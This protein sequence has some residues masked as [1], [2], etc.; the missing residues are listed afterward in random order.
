MFFCVLGIKLTSPGPVLF[1]QARI[2]YRN[3]EFNVFKFRSMHLTRLNSLELTIRNDPRIFA[4]GELMRKLSLDELPQ[5]LNVLRGEM[6]L[7][8]PRRTCLKPGPPA[9]FIMNSSQTMLHGI[10]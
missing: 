1:K 10:G 2:G 6:S 7:V 4:F 3:R 5:L 8:G 9:N